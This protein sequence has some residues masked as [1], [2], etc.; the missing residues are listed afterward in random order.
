MPIET[1]AATGTRYYLVALDEKGRERSD[2]SDGRMRDRILEAIRAERPTDIFVFIHGWK[3]DM[4]AA[5]QQYASW[6]AT[7][8]AQSG[9]IARA[10]PDFVPLLIGLHWPSLPFGEESLAAAAGESFGIG[11]DAIE[12]EVE[13]AAMQIA[14]TPAA[15]AAL[16]T[17]FEAAQGEFTP[18]SLPAEVAEAYRV[19]DGEAALGAQGVEG[20]PG[21]DREPFDP[22]AAYAR[23]LE[24][25]D[26]FGGGGARKALLSPLVQLSFWKMKERA[27]RIGESGG[28]ELLS[29]LM[30]ATSDRNV[31]FH[32][33]GHSFGSIAAS[34]SACGPA[35]AKLPRRVQSVVLVQG[36]LS[37]WSCCDSLPDSPRKAGYFRRLA[38]GDVVAG[39]IVT[40]RSEHDMAVGSLYPVAAGVARQVDFAPGAFPKYGGVGTFG[41]RG[42]GLEIVDLD[43]QDAS[44]AYGFKPGHIYNVNCNRVIREGGP[45]SGAHSDIARPEVGHLVWSAALS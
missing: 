31:R 41:L 44:F 32:L 35:N 34:A 17:I 19:L 8:M 39:P 23:A 43:V 42:G 30:A 18:A 26:S 37:L 22:A 4:P 24:G 45:P 3:G 33:M 20:D 9:D 11:G 36:A 29:A 28:F 1:L 15:R 5:R 16:R 13:A 21:S 2:D 10:G 38:A 27:R 14:D 25:A 7:L 12:A 40:T 6:M